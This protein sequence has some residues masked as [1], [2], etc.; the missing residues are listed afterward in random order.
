[1]NLRLIIN[2]L[3]RLFVVLALVMLATAGIF[4][5]A[6]L[7]VGHL[8]EREAAIALMAAGT[9]GLALGGSAWSLTRAAPHLLARREAMLL[10]SLSWLLGSA[11]AALPFYLWARLGPTAAPHS[12]LRSFINCYFEAVSGFTTVGASVLTDIEAVPRSLLLWRATTQWLGGIGIVVLFVAVLPSLGVGAKKLY[13]FETSGIASG[14]VRPTIRATARVLITIYIVFT[15]VQAVLLTIAGMTPFDAIGHSFC[16][17]ATGGYSPKNTSI[18]HYDSLAID[19]IITV[20]MVLGGVNFAM[21]YHAC[22]GRAD[23]V[24]ADPELRLYLVLLLGS[25][26]MVAWMI[27]GEPITLTTGE[28]RIA[29]GFEAARQAAFNVTSVATTTGY[30]TADYDRWPAAAK[31]LMCTVML[32]GGCAGSTAG[33]LKVVRVLLAFKI[34]LALIERAFRPQVVRPIKIAGTVIDDESQLTALGYILGALVILAAGT[35]AVMLLD[36]QRGIDLATAASANLA[37]F[38][39]IG[40]GFGLVGPVANYGWMSDGSKLVL[41][42]SM[43]LGRLEIFALIALLTPRFWRER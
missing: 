31:V 14:G 20:F 4:Y 35:A 37:T 22:R 28:Q 32:I 18:G 6:E 7:L 27:A 24:L 42:L 43:I 1:V 36:Q 19:A 8:V 39:T 5:A 33:G 41:C 30:A 17:I 26:A 3:G 23:R 2:L 40:P 10:V 9:L 13:E 25:I 34:L 38:C 12:P 16:A 11:L 29:G 21:Y 15:L